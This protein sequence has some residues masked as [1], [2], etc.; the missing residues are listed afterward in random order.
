MHRWTFPTS[1]LT[2]LHR[3]AD[4][5]MRQLQLCS[6]RPWFLQRTIPPRRA[7]PYPITHQGSLENGS[8]PISASSNLGGV[9][10]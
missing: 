2:R 10:P 7:I 8:T 3:K 6:C 9:K 4:R 5:G 1:L